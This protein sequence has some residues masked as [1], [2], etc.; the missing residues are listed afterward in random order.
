M[1]FQLV[2]PGTK[3]DFIGKR[4]ICALLSVLMLLLSLAA[5]P[6]RG[7]RLGIDFAGGT[8]FQVR[9]APDAGAGEGAIRSIVTSCGVSD[10]SVIR[11]GETDASEFLIR[12]RP[13]YPQQLTAGGQDKAVAHQSKRQWQEPVC[14]PG[15][16]IE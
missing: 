11:Y 3:I 10:P 13:E 5:I 16:Q 4:R 12:F 7:I 6:V 1:P 9:F 15:G 8:E 14:D 2:P